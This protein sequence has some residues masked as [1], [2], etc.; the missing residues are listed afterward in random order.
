MKISKTLFSII[1]LFALIAAPAAAVQLVFSDGFNDG[2]LCSWGPSGCTTLVF[3]DSSAEAPVNG[4]EEWADYTVQFTLHAGGR[5]L[6]FEKEAA[7]GTS[8]NLTKGFWF[9]IESYSAIYNGGVTPFSISGSCPY[10]QP[11]VDTPTHFKVSA[12]TTRTFWLNV[13][14]DNA[15]GVVGYYQMQLTGLSYKFD[16]ANGDA[17]TLVTA[18]MSDL[19]T[20][21]IFVENQDVNN[22]GVDATSYDDFHQTTSQ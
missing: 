10:P 18:G 16:G 11:C 14:L 4:H 2:T 5:D 17:T 15:G 6:W 12:N 21:F 22:L 19:D 9:S 13:R 20:V 8:P 3:V 1:A 7:R